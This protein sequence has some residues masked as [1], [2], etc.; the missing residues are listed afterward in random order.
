MGELGKLEK[1]KNRADLEFAGAM[2]S[3]DT[4]KG[5]ALDAQKNR[6]RE[7]VQPKGIFR[8]AKARKALTDILQKDFTSQKWIGEKQGKRDSKKNIQKAYRKLSGDTSLFGGL[9][10]ADKATR[11]AELEKRRIRSAEASRML[12]ESAASDQMGEELSKEEM[13]DS[14]VHVDLEQF[15]IAED[16]EFLTHFKK[17]MGLLQRGEMLMEYFKTEEGQKVM[18]AHQELA[19]KLYWMEKIRAAY[20]ER[21]TVISSPYYVSI[22]EKDLTPKTI[23]HMQNM[24]S[25]KGKDALND[26]DKMHY[27]ALLDYHERQ[28]GELRGSLVFRFNTIEN[29][30]LKVNSRVPEQRLKEHFYQQLHANEKMR[31]GFDELEN[32]NA[33][34]QLVERFFE[35]FEEET[36]G[37]EKETLLNNKHS[38]RGVYFISESRDQRL[39]QDLYGNT[40]TSNVQMTKEQFK[41]AVSQMKVRITEA[42]KEHDKWAQRKSDWIQEHTR[43]GAQNPFN[44]HETKE[45]REERFGK[46]PK[47]FSFAEKQGFA[48]VMSILDDIVKKVDAGEISLDTARIWLDRSYTE[49][50]LDVGGEAFEKELFRQQEKE[51]KPANFDDLSYEEKMQ[52]RKQAEEQKKAKKAADLK[53][54]GVIVNKYAKY[55]GQ[56][57]FLGLGGQALK[58]QEELGELPQEKSSVIRLFG[59][60][61]GGATDSESRVVISASPEHKNEAVENFLEHAAQTGMLR[62]L[63]VNIRTGAQDPR[64]DDI[65]V[66]FSREFEREQIEEFMKQ[67]SAKCR[68]KNEEILPKEDS[69]TYVFGQKLAD[70][71]T[72]APQLPVDMLNWAKELTPE[73]AEYSNKDLSDERLA[74]LD[75]QRKRMKKKERPPHQ[76][77]DKFITE[78]IGLSYQIA[79]ARLRGMRNVLGSGS[80]LDKLDFND[81]LLR[82]EM[83]RV[84]KELMLL[85][86]IDPATMTSI[87]EKKSVKKQPVSLK[88]MLDTLEAQHKA[89]AEQ[90]N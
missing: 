43:N 19:M 85:H 61:F 28:S 84:F 73:L 8:S 24:L 39:E 55:L 44:P 15:N 27:R 47:E 18:G 40:D 16:S 30:E 62:Y 56:K 48:Q 3:L 52:Y 69:Q 66:H 67:Y 82:G 51:E 49:K 20:L 9:S 57:G 71:I 76:A 89:E 11:K 88:D 7:E 53:D 63:N 75:A 31:E 64:N 60:S 83:K 46:E 29:G 74:T 81:R 32:K 25:K 70:G 86:G 36:Y 65:V 78:Q 37:G 79:Y 26:A 2:K 72:I 68:E 34:G 21:I 10:R 80:T 42:L 90:D 12:A 5:R 33:S 23:R 77:H 54:L 22:R 14:L 87:T 1:V 4:L 45:E 6:E 41:E 35:R 38:S 58:P 59:S 17:N 13:M 50:K